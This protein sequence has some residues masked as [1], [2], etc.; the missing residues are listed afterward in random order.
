MYVI[1]LAAK[2][3]AHQIF[4]NGDKSLKSTI[5]VMSITF[6]CSTILIYIHKCN[7]I[8]RDWYKCTFT[9]CFFTYSAHLHVHKRRVLKAT[10]E[11]F[12]KKKDTKT[13]THTIH[14]KSKPFNQLEFCRITSARCSKRI[15]S[16]SKSFNNCSC[17][18]RYKRIVASDQTS[19]FIVHFV[20]FIG[21]R[22]PFDGRT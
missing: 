19:S 18:R 20:G 7:P 5:Q 22:M 15:G 11:I 16:M 6:H 4:F 1:L 10:E 17:R 21:F 8:H 2:Q 14:V 9:N 13:H 3:I 12:I